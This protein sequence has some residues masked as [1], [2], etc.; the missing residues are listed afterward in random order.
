M[1]TIPIRKNSHSPRRIVVAD[2]PWPDAGVGGLTRSMNTRASLGKDRRTV[3]SQGF[4]IERVL[5]KMEDSTAAQHAEPMD[6][7]DVVERVN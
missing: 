4:G 5:A 2:R 3:F 7:R 6:E 1:P